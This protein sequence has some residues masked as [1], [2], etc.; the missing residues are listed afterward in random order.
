M[1]RIPLD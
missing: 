1:K